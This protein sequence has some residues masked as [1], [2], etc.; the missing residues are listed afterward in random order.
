MFNTLANVLGHAHTIILV[1]PGSANALSQSLREMLNQ[2]TLVFG[3]TWWDYLVIGVSFWHY[4]Q[5]SI[6][7]RTCHPE[8]L[9]FCKN[10]TFFA[11]K[12]DV[13][14]QEEF[15]L[16]RNFT[17]LFMDSSS[18]IEGPP[19]FN[20]NN[21]V[22]KWHW[23][24]QTG[25]LWD[26]REKAFSFWTIDDTRN[27]VTSMQNQIDENRDQIDILK[28]AVENLLEKQLPIGSIIPW[29]GS[30]NSNTSLP[31]GWKLCNGSQI[32]DP[33]SPMLSHD[34][35]NLNGDGLFIRGGSEE[36]AGG[37]EGDAI[38]NHT[39]EDLG[40]TH[41]VIFF[42]CS[43]INLSSSRIKDITITTAKMPII[44]VTKY[45]SGMP[46]TASTTPLES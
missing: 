15:K 42:L 5:C 22:Q 21:L 26:Q 43:S 23:E 18:Q 11:R 32:V 33:S 10:E 34:T 9:E 3:K 20:T 19:N 46:I 36:E 45:W 28:F 2:M 16:E 27:K 40:H 8:Y 1:I 13:L 38:R 30:S 24:D 37:I 6:D 17:Y 44:T 14:M 25:R 7:G 31:N 41:T 4:D 29:Y 12:I 35:P 39:H